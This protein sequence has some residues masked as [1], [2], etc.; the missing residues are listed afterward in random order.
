VINKIPKYFKTFFFNLCFVLFC[1]LF[2]LDT[3]AQTT[4]KNKGILEEATI[5]L[6]KKW[7]SILF[8]RSK[9]QGQLFR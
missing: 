6:S 2:S 5:M 9:D 4:Q 7:Y 8:A 1:L 3:F